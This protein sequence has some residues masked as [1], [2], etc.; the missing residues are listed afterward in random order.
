MSTFLEAPPCLDSQPAGCPPG[1]AEGEAASNLPFIDYLRFVRHLLFEPAYSRHA[2]ALAGPDRADQIAAFLLECCL[3]AL[4]RRAQQE[5]EAAVAA[6]QPVSKA[7]LALRDV[8]ASS[9]LSAALL[10]LIAQP[11]GAAVVP[12]LASLARALPLHLPAVS[13]ADL[14]A[15]HALVLELLL[16]ACKC[17]DTAAGQACSGAGAGT[18]CSAGGSNI[19]GSSIPGSS[20]AAEQPGARDSAQAAAAWTVLGLVPHAV[21]LLHTAI[22][23]PLCPPEAL[24]SILTH[25]AALAAYLAMLEHFERP[26]GQVE[27][28]AAAAT[29]SVR[30]LPALHQLLQR[31]WLAEA[32]PLGVACGTAQTAA[33]C[34]LSCVLLRPPTIEQLCMPSGSAEAALGVERMAHAMWAAHS[35]NCRLLHWLAADRQRAR[36]REVFGGQVEEAVLWAALLDMLEAEFTATVEAFRLLQS[37]QAEATVE[38][39]RLELRWVPGMAGAGSRCIVHHCHPPHGPAVAAAAAATRLPCGCAPMPGRSLCAIGMRGRQ[40]RVPCWLQRHPGG[41]TAPQSRLQLSTRG[42][43]ACVRCLQQLRSV[44]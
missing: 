40:P 33:R 4:L 22:T 20:A 43:W 7:L 29:A 15:A 16:Q 21:A 30:A 27:V 17:T 39:A 41:A 37:V 35:A 3:P 32:A 8:F 24:R 28:W 9:S 31:G 1:E 42:C 2:A 13:S 5:P 38:K 36:L 44:Q 6:G 11:R 10:R 18:S 23:D 34:L 25:V 12:C 14:Y 26:V 19:P